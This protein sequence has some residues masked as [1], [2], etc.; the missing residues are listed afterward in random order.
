M[1]ELCE[2]GDFRLKRKRVLK[3]RRNTVD[4]VYRDGNHSIQLT[5]D[6]RVKLMSEV[7]AVIV[8]L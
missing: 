1:M 7:N 3:G 8:V 2:T 5:I 6:N 4:K